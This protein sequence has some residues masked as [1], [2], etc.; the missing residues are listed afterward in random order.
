MDCLLF[1]HTSGKQQRF[2]MQQKPFD[3]F[4]FLLQLETTISDIFD[5][6]GPGNCPELS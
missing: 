4:D 6:V 2:L 5:E 3:R 1:D